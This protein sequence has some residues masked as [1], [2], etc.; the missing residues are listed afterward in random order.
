MGRRQRKGEWLVVSGENFMSLQT[1]YQCSECGDMISTYY[2]PGACEHCGS[3]NKYKGNL[4]LASIK[5]EQ[6]IFDIEQLVF[7]QNS[8]CTTCSNNPKNGGS[9]IC[10][11]ILGQ[12]V[13]C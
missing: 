11:C 7:Q 9:G 1:Q 13:V 4:I 3:I 6:D 5:D 2:P 8:V 12:Q 10:N